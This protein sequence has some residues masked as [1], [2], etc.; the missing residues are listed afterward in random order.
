MKRWKKIIFVAAGVLCSGGIVGGTIVSAVFNEEEAVHIREGE[1]E[2]STLII[3]THLIHISALSDSLYDIASETAE[4]SG[5]Y[6]MY[7]KSELGEG[8]W[9]EISDASGL[10]DIMEEGTA[11]DGS[12]IEELFLRYHTKSDGITYDLKTGDSVCIFDIINPYSIYTLPELEAISMHYDVLREKTGKTETDERNMELIEAVA[13]EDLKTMLN[14]EDTDQ[15]IESLQSY[16][17]YSSSSG[18]ETSQTVLSLMEE[19]DS[20]RRKEVYTYL[21]Y[22]SL[23]KLLEDVQRQDGAEGFY[24]D[25]ELVGAVGTAMDEVEK[26]LT[27]YEAKSWEN[28]STAAGREK[29]RLKEEAIA[30]AK[31]G[32]ISQLDSLM[33]NIEDLI[34]IEQGITK[35]PKR[36]A[37]MIKDILVPEALNVAANTGADD[38]ERQSALWETEF[39][40]KTALSAM[41]S[42]TA[43][44]FLQSI[45]DKITQIENDANVSDELLSSVESLK[46]QVLEMKGNLQGETSLMSELFAKKEELKLER[47][48]SL[49]K[50]NLTR[51]KEFEEELNDLE[52]EI[53]K[54]ENRLSDILTSDTSSNEEKEAAKS[55]L[56][57]GTSSM[58][59]IETKEN[60][61]SALEEGEYDEAMDGAASLETFMATNS[62][63][64]LSSLQDIY[65]DVLAEIYLK[66]N[67]NIVLKEIK[68]NLE[69]V[70]SENTD[71]IE[72]EIS[73]ESLLG[74]IEE[75]VGTVFGDMNDRDK[76]ATAVSLYSFGD[77]T[78]NSEVKSMGE[79]LI[80]KLYGEDNPYVYEKLKSETKEFIGLK[81]FSRCSNYRYIF[82]NGSKSVT[83]RK[84]TSY[85]T[86]TVF[87]T[88]V[89]TREGKED[90]ETYARFQ[91]DI[92]L[93]EEYMEEK[94]NVTC[95]YI[96]NTSYSIIIDEKINERAAEFTESLYYYGTG[97]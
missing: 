7:Y 60:V 3:G 67:D 16:Y 86:Y 36:E 13:E 87:K 12:V 33:E 35:N 19:L 49:D 28:D 18:S 77:E 14:Q 27:E 23:P 32:S 40:A 68:D 53:E 5:Q 91:S 63:L 4:I 22:E 54:E 80:S 83:L 92:Y 39:L 21:Y 41:G 65:N 37:Q 8:R 2:N 17:E 1:I 58:L 97:N 57:A 25:Y 24:V 59:I 85:Y 11:V 45:A 74:L 6:N 62:N 78:N 81:A 15:D 46:S 69:S 94:F 90:M 43:S 95:M 29:L 52:E 50:N 73:A 47:M 20:Q 89:S 93:A 38:E 64:V 31:E 42:E 88:N 75:L 96:D 55:A 84:G 26:K 30:M 10:S 76:A 61:Q 71:T 70:I 72:G 51:A 82:Y 48:A 9:Y 34:N 56:E 79:G 66:G 44:D